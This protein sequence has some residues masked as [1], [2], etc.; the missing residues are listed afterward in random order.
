MAFAKIVLFW[1]LSLA[2]V[3]VHAQINRYMV[4]FKDKSGTSFTLQNPAAYLSEKA[5]VRRINQG[6]LVNAQDIPVNANYI[7]GVRNAGV[8]VYFKSRWLNGVLVQCDQSLVATLQ[9]LSYVDR[10]EFVAPNKKL[11]NSGRRKINMKKKN[12]ASGFETQS[13]L[14]MIGINDMH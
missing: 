8:E 14:S 11:I 12:G 13:Q 4:F 1:I 3:A 9:A 5:I 2:A 7:D 6:L 10:V